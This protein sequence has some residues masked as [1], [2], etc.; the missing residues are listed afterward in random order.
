MKK[1]VSMLAAMLAALLTVS[2]CGTSTT[3]AAAATTAAADGGAKTAASTTAAPAAEA[4][5]AKIAW[6]IL[7]NPPS[8]LQAVTDAVN[9]IS[10]PKVNVKVELD[11]IPMASWFTQTNL[12]MSSGEKLDLTIVYNRDGLFSQNVA[13]G[14]L[15]AIDDLLAEHG[16]GIVQAISE[17]SP[18]YLV[19]GK[20][21]GKTYGVTQL[22]DLATTSGLCARK[23]VVDQVGLDV[24]KP[25]TIASLETT[26]Q[27]VKELN[28]DMVPLVPFNVGNTIANGF[29]DIDNLGDTMGVLMKYG[30]DS[31]T[32]VNYFETPEYAALVGTMHDWYEKGYILADATTNTNNGVA[33]V[34]A[35]TAF[36][37]VSTL[38]PGYAN[39]TSQQ[40]GFEMVT[41]DITEP[42]ASTNQVNNFLWCVPTN[43]KDPVS[44]MKFLNLM[45]TDAE[46]ANLLVWG[47]EGKHY[48]KASDN[49]GV[50]T[51]PEGVD[52]TNTGWG[53]NLGWEMGNQF[54]T[55]VWEGDAPDL[56]TQMADF[57]KSAVQSKAMGFVFDA[58]SVK[59]QM[60]AV[61]NVMNQY[62]PGLE[63]GLSDP[64]KVLPQFIADLKANGIDEIVKAKQTQLDAYL[65][66]N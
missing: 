22:R 31:T 61:K 42:H 30:Q 65:A 41:A 6:L 48:V 18:A 44:S 36:G 12:M 52:G 19:P 50:I 55:W 24:S 54:L 5:T 59:S 8:D 60:A 39:Q 15:L 33:L 20:I 21:N 13:S 11:P 45:Y 35:G 64:A 9:A 37:F 38:K 2:G 17:L 25:L 57:N 46:I 26:L 10:V 23:D 28:P 47:I 40:T 16:Q 49:S 51:Y 34:K 32:V 43:S 1:S 58:S 56:W 53:L 62:V 7:T 63:D 29:Y 3:G 66:A 4:Y 14:K 27:K